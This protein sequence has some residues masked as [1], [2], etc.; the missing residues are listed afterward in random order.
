MEV[1]SQPT[2][3]PYLPPTPFLF[4][5]FAGTT[6][7]HAFQAVLTSKMLPLPNIKWPL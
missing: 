2:S 4:V 1:Y 7:P 3:C 6:V 5:M